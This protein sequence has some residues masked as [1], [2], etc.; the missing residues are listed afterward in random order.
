MM[1]SVGL[2]IAGTGAPC[3]NCESGDRGNRRTRLAAATESK[4]SYPPYPQPVG[5]GVHMS[6]NPDEA[7]SRRARIRLGWLS[8]DAPTGLSGCFP[9]R[10]GLGIAGRREP[11]P[12][13]PAV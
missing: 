10:C 5:S 1:E 4:Q 11:A 2:W 9:Q 3:P 12:P 7:D 6:A 8:P 13:S